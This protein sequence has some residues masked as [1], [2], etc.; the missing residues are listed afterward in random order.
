MRNYAAGQLSGSL[1]R[2]A[3]EVR[4]AS[5]HGRPD[6]VHDLRVSI[7]RFLA[8]LSIFRDHF[9]S[10][11]AKKC[12]RRLRRVL[13]LAA[14]VR[15]RDVSIELVGQAGAGPRS[16]LFG[17]L[18]ETRHSAMEELVEELCRLNRREFSR[19]WRAALELSGNESKESS[20]ASLEAAVRYA[21]GELPSLAQEFFK[22][23]RRAAAPS[24]LPKALHRFRLATKRFRYE[25]E[26]FRPLYGPGLAARLAVLRSVQR[27]LG[28]VNDCAAACELLRGAPAAMARSSAAAA[29]RIAVLGERR[30]HA[31]RLYWNKEVASP[32]IEQNWID[33]L[34]RYAGRKPAPRRS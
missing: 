9:S 31:F 8:C 3:F 33:Y 11:V 27:H 34:T 2:L 23:G 1:T 30:V 20:V 7:R 10:R 17:W 24:Q 26:L 6:E 19:R 15:N 22:R 25:V 32:K 28:E 4:R 5:R 13:D 18:T 21:S 16:A 14:E 29:R 12:R